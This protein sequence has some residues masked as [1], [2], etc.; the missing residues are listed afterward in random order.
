M[1]KVRELLNEKGTHVW[2]ITPDRSAH[3]ALRLMT[4]KNVGAV[5]VMDDGQLL[6]IFSERDFI[7]NVAGRG[8]AAG[9]IPVGEFMTH[10]PV[11]VNPDQTTEECMALMTDKRVRHLPVIESDRVI[12]LVSIGDA[13]K[14]TISEQQFMIE[15]LE[16]YIN[17]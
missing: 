10:R 6:G 15:Q 12:G 13:V 16:R 2:S 11:C 4:E 5:L 1:K 7:R 9:D 3:E 14:A 17:T 8:G